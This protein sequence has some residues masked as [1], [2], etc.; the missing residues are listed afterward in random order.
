[1][2]SP[3]SLG[4]VPG[5]GGQRLALGSGTELLGPGRPL[6]VRDAASDPHRS[7]G[8]RAAAA[9]T[10][11]VA[12]D[13][14]GPPCARRHDSG[15]LRQGDDQPIRLRLADGPGLRVIPLA[16]RLGGVRSGATAGIHR[17]ARGT[18]H[19]VGRS[20]LLQPVPLARADHLVAQGSRH[21]GLRR[22][23][24][25]PAESGHRWDR[26][27]C[28]LCGHLQVRGTARTP[29]E[30]PNPHEGRGRRGSGGALSFP[31]PEDGSVRRTTATG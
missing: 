23:S 14:G 11:V 22:C 3:P 16:D 2:P 25:L 13:R 15:R 6:R 9:P 21:A 30:V 19:R 7:C 1:L 5:S 31:T 24:E 20:G 26:L 17:M 8:G 18:A 4:G 27:A 12:G 28:S 10:R 29:T